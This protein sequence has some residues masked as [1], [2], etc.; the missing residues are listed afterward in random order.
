M[1]HRE[2]GPFLNSGM[3]IEKLANIPTPAWRGVEA[4]TQLTMLGTR[5]YGL[6][7]VL[8]SF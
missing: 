8:F 2:T 1:D 6:G 4:V 7:R 3:A 5:R